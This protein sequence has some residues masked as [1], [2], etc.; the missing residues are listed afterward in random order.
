M[1]R[2]M[3]GLLIFAV[4]LVGCES[5][6]DRTLEVSPQ[7]T[8]RPIAE[9]PEL[10]TAEPQ[11]IVVR[12]DGREILT[13]RG[14]T[15][16][17]NDTPVSYAFFAKAA[18]S[19]PAATSTPATQPAVVR[20]HYLLKSSPPVAPPISCEI[21]YRA[22][23][24]S[25]TITLSADAELPSISLLATLGKDVLPVR[26]NR[27]PS[28]QVVQTA[29]GPAVNALFDGLLESKHGMAIAI[30][31]QVAFL[32]GRP[33]IHL[34]ASLEQPAGKRA[35]VLTLTAR[36][37]LLRQIP[38]VMVADHPDDNR[39]D[40]GAGWVACP[41]D[42]ATDP[43]A[44]LLNARW[45]AA[46]LGPFGL[47][48]VWT[49]G[50]AKALEPLGLTT[51]PCRRVGGP[52][53]E[54][55][56]LSASSMATLEAARREASARGLA[57]P[58]LLLEGELHRLSAEQV[59]P[60]RRVCPPAPVRAVDLFDGERP[61]LWNLAIATAFDHWNVLGVFNSSSEPE[62]R[63]IELGRLGIPVNDNA[64]Y[65]VYDFWQQQLLAVARN[66][67]DVDLEPASCRVLCIRRLRRGRPTLISTSRHVTQ[68]AIDLHDVQFD[69]QTL[70]MSGR[71]NVVAGDPYELCIFAG[72][73][74]E[75]FEITG[76]EA[77]SA[78]TLVRAAGPV[79]IVTLE[80]R[81]TRALPWS[82]AFVKAPR[83]VA[84]P[85]PPGGVSA[86]QNTRGVLLSWNP[87]DDQAVSQRIYR[88]NEPIAD[89]AGR[90]YEFQDSGV[91]YNTEYVYAVTAVD[92]A[93]RESDRS[94]PITHRTPI[95]AST[96]LTQ[97]APLSAKQGPLPLGVN[98][99][100]GG[101]P[102]R[103]AGRRYAR[104]LGM[105]ANAHVTY[106][107][108]GGYDTFSAEIGIDDETRGKGSVVFK[109]SADDTLMFKSDVLH[110]GE[111][112]QPLKV[113]IKDRKLL[114][115]SVESAGDGIEGDHADWGD[116]HLQ[117]TRKPD[118]KP[119]RGP[120]QSTRPAMQPGA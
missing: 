78:T 44:L 86:R 34:R 61:G 47:Q 111:P 9:A 40:T 120:A 98:K 110:A 58:W 85:T 15:A 107:L 81:Q 50:R 65:A 20:E 94:P 76:I 11:D 10:V 48:Y 3:R 115:L 59:E 25:A 100:A 66:R 27:P 89:V 84:L 99:S 38:P 39:I 43:E 83:P 91:V 56:R 35:T 106:F 95:P 18:A 21:A 5:P 54:I 22:G 112:P 24:A 119:A 114:T 108:G 1:Q 73:G 82:I 52:L 17:F 103:I 30:D 49:D 26:L 68:G 67:F 75:R 97:L 87:R 45:V 118:P 29:I 33:G 92:F 6:P 16:R 23:P 51:E 113:S 117:A 36:K 12:L 4:L 42:G 2:L 46:N 101:S 53:L 79:Q 37:T 74:D 71:S 105:C 57:Y 70:R 31:G 32:P 62:R 88:N 28:R 13:L 41:Q 116:A 72:E 104:G 80:S 14:A 64:R 63:A 8:T 96:S 69:P 93:G 7:P 55:P 90:R 109:I 60:L 77:A 19:Q 102:L